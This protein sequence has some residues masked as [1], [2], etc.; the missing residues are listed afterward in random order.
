MFYPAYSVLANPAVRPGAMHMYS[1][2]QGSFHHQHLQPTAA[3]TVGIIQPVPQHVQPQAKRVYV[4]FVFVVDLLILF[5]LVC[6]KPCAW[7]RQLTETN[8]FSATTDG[9][10]QS[11]Y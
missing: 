9:R 11:Q 4:L 6:V 8:I 1:Q 10:S 5:Y 7:I 2:Q 3:A